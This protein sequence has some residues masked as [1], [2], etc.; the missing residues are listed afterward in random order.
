[1]IFKYYPMILGITEKLND[2]NEKINEMLGSKLDNV[3][4]GTLVLGAILVVAFWGIS[5]LN[6]H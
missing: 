1:M 6:K 5:E 2:L 3:F 4:I